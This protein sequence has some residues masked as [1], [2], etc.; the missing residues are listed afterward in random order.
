MFLLLLYLVAFHFWLL[1]SAVD[2]A[3]SVGSMA[4]GA[5]NGKF[6]EGYFV[7]VVVGTEKLSGVL[8]HVSAG[9][10]AQQYANV[11]SL[12]DSIGS[13]E[14]TPGMEIQLY[15]CKKRKEYVR[16]I[17]PD[18]PKRTRTAYN[19]YF[20]EQRAKLNQ[21]YPETKG[22]G[23]KVTEMWNKLSDEEKAVSW[24]QVVGVLFT[25]IPSFLIFSYFSLYCSLT[26]HVVVKKG[27]STLQ[28]TE[29]R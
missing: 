11:P 20:K 7:T 23:K 12:V 16:K 4:T 26:L 29:R 6:E 10:K 21:L 14:N 17:N 9:N 5:I 3:A 2:P 25:F 28:N 1:H 24:C 13:E 22:L 19:I 8:Y 15:G 27:K 18:A